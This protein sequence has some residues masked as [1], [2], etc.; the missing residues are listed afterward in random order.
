MICCRLCSG[1]ASNQLLCQRK[2]ESKSLENTLRNCNIQ[3][4]IFK[5][6]LKKVIF[7]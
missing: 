7:Y 4:N 1:K 2:H 6:E 3:T 5:Q